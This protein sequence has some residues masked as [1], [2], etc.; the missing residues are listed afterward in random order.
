MHCILPHPSLS[1]PTPVE[2]QGL[3][4]QLSPNPGVNSFA[5]R[6]QTPIRP[7]A[8]SPYLGFGYNL[9]SGYP[10]NELF[11]NDGRISIQ[12]L[13]GQPPGKNTFPSLPSYHRL[14]IDSLIKPGTVLTGFHPG[15][16]RC[17]QRCYK[18]YLLRWKPPR[19]R[20]RRRNTQPR[21]PRS[22]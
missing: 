6:T 19:C 7:N 22:P 16:S 2:T 10:R 14:M 17:H 1:A 18:P 4:S 15:C 8:N 5:Q 21:P 12:Q 13:D 9:L 20:L 3:S 11:E